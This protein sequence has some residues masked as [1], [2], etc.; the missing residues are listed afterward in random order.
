MWAAGHLVGPTNCFSPRQGYFDVDACEFHLKTRKHGE[1][2]LHI[3][4]CT[5]LLQVKA[6]AVKSMDYFSIP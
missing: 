5:P 6:D 3:S 4:A 1:M 2:F